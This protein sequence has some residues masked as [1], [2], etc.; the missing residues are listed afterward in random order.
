[1]DTNGD[2]VIREDEVPEERRGMLRFLSMRLGQD[3]SQGIS[4]EKLRQTLGSRG[5]QT[6]PG[7]S[8]GAPDKSKTEEPLVPGFGTDHQPVLAAG[9]GVRIDFEGRVTSLALLN[10]DSQTRALFARCDLNQNGVLE[11]NE[12]VGLPRGGDG[13]DQNRDGVISVA[14]LS[15]HLASAQRRPRE[16][17]SAGDDGSEGDDAESEETK[18][19][20]YRFRSPHE[21]LPKDLPGWFA[22]RDADLDGQVSMAEFA[23]HW[24]PSTVGE[25]RNYDTNRDGMITPEECLRP[26]G[27]AAVQTPV[28]LPEVS[29]PSQ[30]SGGEKSKHWWE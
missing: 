27:G 15:S 21:R 25:F 30:P 14:E 19:A 7:Q 8:D 18:P 4:L 12:W 1:M 24:T 22:Q 26:G 2:G 17:D 29:P 3:P 9:F 11:R 6:P 10:A 16:D 5:S 23:V 28:R 13:I 20:S